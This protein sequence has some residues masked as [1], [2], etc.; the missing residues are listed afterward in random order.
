MCVFNGLGSSCA[1]FALSTCARG[2]AFPAIVV[3]EESRSHPH[4]TL[5]RISFKIAGASNGSTGLLTALPR[6]R[7]EPDALKDS[8]PERRAILDPMLGGRWLDLPGIKI[9]QILVWGARA[10]FSSRP[11]DGLCANHAPIA[12]MGSVA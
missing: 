2:H 9:P 8:A 1:D 5:Q 7:S 12:A 3:E 10:I 11:E 4:A 6:R